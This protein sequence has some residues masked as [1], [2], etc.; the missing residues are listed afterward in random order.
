MLLWFYFLNPRPTEKEIVKFYNTFD[1]DP[2]ILQVYFITYK[3]LSNG[4]IH[5]LKV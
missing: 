2:I 3:N 1:Y 4:N 5:L